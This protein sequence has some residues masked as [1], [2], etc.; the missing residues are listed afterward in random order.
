MI[1]LWTRITETLLLSYG[2][3]FKFQSAPPRRAKPRHCAGHIWLRDGVPPAL[4][5]EEGPPYEGGP[6]WRI[7]QVSPSFR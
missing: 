6:I 7:E 2:R 5:R 3:L 4:I 1:Q